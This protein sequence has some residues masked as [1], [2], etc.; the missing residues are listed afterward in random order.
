MYGGN[1]MKQIVL[2]VVLFISMMFAMLF[3]ILSPTVTTAGEMFVHVSL[4]GLGGLV[5]V[6]AV[7]FALKQRMIDKA[8]E[9]NGENCFGIVI[10]VYPGNYGQDETPIYNADVL[11]YVSS[12]RQIRIVKESIGSDRYKYPTKSYLSCK[13]YNGDVNIE[14]LAKVNEIPDNIKE[15]L[16]TAMK[17]TV[18]PRVNII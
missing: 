12:L 15:Q 17:Q 10:R 9:E 13:Y 7:V 6:L 3:A 8:T 11:I 14:G 4:C 5:G 16:E 2:G 18:A 1:K